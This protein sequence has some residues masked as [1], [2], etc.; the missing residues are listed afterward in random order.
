M[1]YSQI[2]RESVAWATDNGRE[3]LRA[4]NDRIQ[5]LDAKAGQLSGFS[6][7]ILA[8]LGSIAPDAFDRNIGAVGEPLFA[9]AYFASVGALTGAILWLVF[10]ALRPQRFIAIDAAELTAYLEDERLLRAQP[11]ALQMRTLRA[12]RDCTSWA[13]RGAELK[14]NRLTIGVVIFAVGLAAALVAVV[15]LG[16]GNLD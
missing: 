10:F 9:S 3:L 11:W 7:V 4:E 1:D 5:A 14:A 13:Q 2:N 12:L 16:V 6:G 15:T 8:V